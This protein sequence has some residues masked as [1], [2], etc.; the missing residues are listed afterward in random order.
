MSLEVTCHKITE[1]GNNICICLSLPMEGPSWRLLHCT[2]GHQ[3]AHWGLQLERGP[4]A[5]LVTF[6]Q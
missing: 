2:G 5:L 3:A 1:E 6:P 4:V